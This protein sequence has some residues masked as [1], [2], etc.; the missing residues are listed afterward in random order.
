VTE[1]EAREE[2]N[3]GNQELG[4]AGVEDRLWTVAQDP[5]GD[6]MLEE[7]LA[8]RSWWDRVISAWLDG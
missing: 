7:V 3:R 6:W 4:E 2:A 8:K 5:S 1:S